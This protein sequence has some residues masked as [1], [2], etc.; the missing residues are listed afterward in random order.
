MAVALATLERGGF[1]LAERPIPPLGQWL[2]ETR[3]RKRFSQ[4]QLAVSSTVSKGYISQLEN[5]YDPRNGQPIRPS[6]DI[7]R[8]LATGLSDGHEDEG[9]SYYEAMMRLAGYL[10]PDEEAGL[11]RGREQTTP[12][13]PGTARMLREWLHLNLGLEDPDADVVLDLAESL[14]RRRERETT[15]DA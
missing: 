9:D 15:S 10:D 13:T 7:L 12:Y 11:E 6:P 14:R 5:G 2:K 4:P 1:R 3:E 8:L